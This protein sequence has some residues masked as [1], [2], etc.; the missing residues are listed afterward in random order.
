LS[1]ASDAVNGFAK[2]IAS[3]V[4]LAMVASLLVFAPHGLDDRAVVTL[5]P[6]FYWERPISQHQTHFYD[7]FLKA[8]QLAR[9]EVCQRDLD[10]HLSLTK[11]DGSHLP[12]MD[13]S[14]WGSEAL[15]V[16]ANTTGAYRIGV[17]AN[18]R[19]SARGTYTITVCNVRSAVSADQ[20][21]DLAQYLFA[22]GMRET[23]DDT[24]ASMAMAVRSFN[25]ASAHWHAAGDARREAQ[26]LNR[27]GFVCQRTGRYQEAVD[28]FQRALRIWQDLKD[29][30][31]LAE[32]WPQLAN[33]AGHFG[34]VAK[35]PW[36]GGQ[37]G[38]E[39][40]QTFAI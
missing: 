11:A 9:V 17:A 33:A 30:Y 16:L 6:G 7:L 36:L 5:L 25:A 37:R 27:L 24:A 14:E 40:R 23:S 31:G 20:N 19:D 1:T 8:G 32:T 38:S 34:I 21:G 35:R 12:D 2:L 4:F 3:T 28:S 15:S 39:P 22:Q 10:V 29:D 13:G 18:E 26:A